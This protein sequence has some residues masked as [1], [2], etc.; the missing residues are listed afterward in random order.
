MSRIRTWHASVIIL[1]MGL[2]GCVKQDA[3]TRAI[4]PTEVKSI[5]INPV[6]D[7]GVIPIGGT[8]SEVV[9][10]RNTTGR[11]IEIGQVST[12]C[13]CVEVGLLSKEL[14]SQE[15]SYARITLK[16]E[17]NEKYAGELMIE[18]KAFDQAGVEVML[19]DVKA[20]I[21]PDAEVRPLLTSGSS[22]GP[23]GAKHLPS[24]AG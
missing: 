7:L 5:A 24:D 11:R 6:V 8:N 1:V 13:A 21:V 10:Y 19:F 3:A 2:G 16:S 4:R 17:K 12:S 9:K 18:V 14:A 20:L 22:L 15:I 23:E